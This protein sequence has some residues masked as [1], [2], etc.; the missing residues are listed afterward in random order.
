MSD[1]VPIGLDTPAVSQIS[2]ACCPWRT[3]LQTPL[4][5]I[6]AAGM[7]FAGQQAWSHRGAWQAALGGASGA[8]QCS[9]AAAPCPTSGGCGSTA[10]LMTAESCPFSTS[11]VEDSGAVSA[12]TPENATS[13]NPAELQTL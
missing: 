6:A 2:P 13:S 8:G 5:L 11:T 9:G 7:G 4:L 3:A 12:L 1:H 10:E